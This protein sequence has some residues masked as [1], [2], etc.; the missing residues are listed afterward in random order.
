MNIERYEYTVNP[1]EGRI[2]YEFCSD[3]PNG[4]IR[5]EIR[6]DEISDNFYNL[7]FGDSTSEKDNFSDSIISNNEDTERVLSTVA[8]VVMEFTNKHPEAMVYGEGSNPARTRL[9]RICLNKHWKIIRKDFNIQGLL[10]NGVWEK[11]RKNGK[12]IAFAGTRKNLYF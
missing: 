4:Q 10:I 8:N 5:K 9:Y 12:Y 11:F 2:Q 3:G 7:S 6:F 1:T